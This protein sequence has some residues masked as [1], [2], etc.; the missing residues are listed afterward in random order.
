MVFLVAESVAFSSWVLEVVSLYLY[1]T[2]FLTSEFISKDLQTTVPWFQNSWSRFKDISKISLILAWILLHQY[3]RE[4]FRSFYI[5][6]KNSEHIVFCFIRLRCVLSGWLPLCTSVNI[7]QI[8]FCFVFN[9]K[10]Q[11]IWFE[12]FPTVE[13][14]TLTFRSPNDKI[15]WIMLEYLLWIVV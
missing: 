15:K 10:A 3:Y 11:I 2:N 9:G 8:A 6:K 1:R 7:W 13:W 5:F 12:I 14:E 4:C